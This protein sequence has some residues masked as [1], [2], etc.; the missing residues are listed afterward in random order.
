MPERLRLG[1]AYG[2]TIGRIKAQGGD[3]SRL[4]MDALMWISNAERPLSA[5]TLCHALAI[6]LGSRDYN[7]ENIPSMST[8]LGCC[9][10]LITVDKE[11]STVRLVHFT[12]KVYLSTHP[13]IFSKPHSAIA[14]ICLTYLNSKQVRAI[15][16]D[17]SPEPL[18]S[19]FLK[20]CSLYWGV[21]A[22]NELSE[23]AKSLALQLLQEYNSHISANLLLGGNDFLEVWDQDTSFQFS[24]LHCA[25]YFGILEVVTALIEM[26]CYGIN[27]GDYWGFTPLAWAAHNG[28]EGV[29]KVLLRQEEASPDKPD[30]YGRTPLSHAALNGHEGV[31]EMLL[32]QEGVDLN[33]P[34]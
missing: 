28:H 17:P 3:K 7:S 16:T 8:L 32:V 30:D 10:G 18:H 14:E 26:Q 1:E 31:V 5:D 20:Y 27:E 22:K 23:A 15:S 19:P 2:G 24:G 6:E 13:E 21:H 25:S 4:G 11:A 29:V 12:L 34:D 9:Q 33:K